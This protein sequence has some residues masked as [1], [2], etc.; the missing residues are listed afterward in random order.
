MAG[1]GVDEVVIGVGRAL[2]D[3]E[4]VF[5]DERRPPIH[6]SQADMI[7]V[8]VNLESRAR[9]QSEP[10]AERLRQHEAPCLVDGDSGTVHT[11]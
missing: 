9:P 2:M 3:P 8:D 7:V 10:I 11:S 1:H 6:G 4:T 5:L